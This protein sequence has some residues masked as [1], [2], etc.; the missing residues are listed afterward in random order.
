MRGVIV[1]GGKGTRLLSLT[2]PL[3]KCLLPVYD[4][5]M[6]MHV[7]STLVK[8]GIT[9][10]MIALDGSHP[11]MFLE[12]LEDGFSLGCSLIY[13]YRRS[14]EGPGRT[15]LLAK[16]WIGDENF[17]L[18]LG[19]SIFLSP[20]TFNGKDVPHMYIMPLEK[21]DNP[22]KYGQVKVTDDRIKSIIWKPVELF[23]D[24]IQTTCFIFPP[25]AFTR[26][27]RL[28]KITRGEVPI[29][30]LTSQYV[31][32]GLMRYTML[33]PHSYIDCGN[34][35]ALHLA[36]KYMSDQNTQSIDDDE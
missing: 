15:L 35:S 17:V 12:M 13:R 6:I 29:T 7:I 34:I 26:L 1:A 4:R 33:A 36:A 30:A 18:I 2:N 32:E 22:Q 14:S 10:I 24:L 25:D 21:F 19:D 20:L 27:H 9:E 3:N 31:T 5:P 16:E 23:S 28:S 11:G 8:G